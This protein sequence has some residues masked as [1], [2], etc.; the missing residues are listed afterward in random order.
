MSNDELREFVTGARRSSNAGKPRM[1]L[2]PWHVF[3]RIGMRY[4][5]PPGID[6][7]NWERGMPATQLAA[8]T[9]RHL[10]AWLNRDESEDHAA[11]VV[12]GALAML[13]HDER[14]KR[15]TLRTDIDDR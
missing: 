9:M 5:P 6:D 2:I 14:W 7:R 4:A 15:G 11:A 13:D 12:W 10:I 1:D 3:D 8:S